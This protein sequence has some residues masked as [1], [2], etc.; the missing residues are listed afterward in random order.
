MLMIE[1]EKQLQICEYETMQPSMV[2]LSDGSAGKK[3]S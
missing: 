1:L 3:I 2:P